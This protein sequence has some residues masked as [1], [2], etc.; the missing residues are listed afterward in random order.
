MLQS[1]ILISFAGLR[2]LGILF[3]DHVHSLLAVD[4]VLEMIAPW[5]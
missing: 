4:E 1:L 5:R 2:G 3:V